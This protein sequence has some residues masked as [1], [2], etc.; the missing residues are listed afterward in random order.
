MG[1]YNIEKQHV[2][3]DLSVVWKG[4]G[5]KQLATYF[6]FLGHGNMDS[7]LYS[8]LLD[9][10]TMYGKVQGGALCLYSSFG[11]SSDFH[12]YMFCSCSNPCTIDIISQ[13]PQCPLLLNH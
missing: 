9:E 7:L 8:S 12:G 3:L 5:S 10:G 4:L 13:Q 1:Q 11:P 6:V 2:H